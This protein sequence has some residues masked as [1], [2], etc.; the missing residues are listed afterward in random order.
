MKTTK[1][2]ENAVTKLYKAFHNNELDHTSCSACA[3]G[4]IV[5]NS[6]WANH[7]GFVCGHELDFI[8]ELRIKKDS[9][10]KKVLQEVITAEKVCLK[11][12]YSVDE[13]IRVEQLFMDCFDGLYS[14]EQS[15]FNGLCAVVKYL[16]QL[17]NIPNV[18]DYTILFE[19]K[20]NKPVKELAF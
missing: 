13:L 20:D 3:V 7:T 5:G 14:H 1:R 12:G 11:T 6:L 2:F 19:T 10:Y 8:D 16:C 4:N 17:D 15:E 9:L 18:M